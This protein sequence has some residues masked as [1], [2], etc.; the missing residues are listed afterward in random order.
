MQEQKIDILKWFLAVLFVSAGIFNYYY[1]A[2][3]ELYLRMGAWILMLLLAGGIALWTSQ[4]RQFLGFA[5]ASRSEM[6]KVVW[7]TRQETVQT[8]MIVAAL[9][10]VT[11]LILWGVDTL[12]M[13]AIAWL[14]GQG[15]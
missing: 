14:T 6:R 1:F 2:D 10:L 13:W 3:Q 11:A 9:V 12:L 4:G 8:T 7:P 5:K 15:S